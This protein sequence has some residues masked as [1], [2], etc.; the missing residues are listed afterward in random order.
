M[1]LDYDAPG[2][3]IGFAPDFTK[4]PEPYGPPLTAALALLEPLRPGASIADIA[5]GYGRYAIPL[6]ERGHNVSILDV[7]RPSLAE[8]ARR[9]SCLA[10]PHGRLHC[11][12]AD[13]LR[14]TLPPMPPFDAVICFGFLHHLSPAGMRDLFVTMRSLLAPGGRLIVELS[15]DKFRRTPSGAPILVNGD[16]EQNLTFTQGL[17][18]LGELHAAVGL[19]PPSVQV[20]ALHVRQ[21]DF[22]YD[23]S[24][25]LSCSIVP[26]F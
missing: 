3:P 20:E 19:H 5:G 22:W 21:S 18:K 10:A 9:A 26:T 12:Q 8:A 17:A 7:H 11:H 24:M 2:D 13:V 15:T 16:P 23:C 4:T 1:A 14:H 25:L 6:I